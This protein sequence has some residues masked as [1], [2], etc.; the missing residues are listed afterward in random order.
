VSRVDRLLEVID[1][2]GRDNSMSL[3]SR[4][5]YAGVDL[6]SVDG[7]GVS[8]ITD[9][10]HRCIG[11]SDSFS[12]GIEALQGSFR[13]GPCFDAVLLGKP[14][15]A[16][17]LNSQ[18]MRARWPRFTQS[19]V[20]AGARSIF[21]FPMAAKGVT[22]GALDL[23]A[24]QPQNMTDNDIA[25]ACVLADL[26]T[27]AV[28]NSLERGEITEVGLSSGL[29]NAWSYPAVVHHAAGMTSVHLDIDIET[30]ML[31]LRARAVGTGRALDDLANDVVA[32]RLRLER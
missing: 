15:F 31:R 17:R 7:A 18:A 20:A 1:R 27:I 8:L 13:E 10:S 21:G 2:T 6:L 3:L 25:D 26:V 19:A 22:F 30:A 12:A 11:S 28:N 32:G 16:P 23:F 29:E 24:K 4:L 5:C 14:I 9:D